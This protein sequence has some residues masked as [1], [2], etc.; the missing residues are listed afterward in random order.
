MRVLQSAVVI[1]LF[2]AG[3]V[4]AQ[5]LPPAPAGYEWARCPDIGGALLVPDGWSFR[6]VAAGD[7]LA[8]FIT[9][10]P[11]EPPASFETGL[12]FNVLWDVPGKTGLSPVEYGR[13]Y[14]DAAKS[15]EDVV[16]SWETQLGPFN[17]FGLVFKGDGEDEGFTFYHL[18]IGNDRTGTAFLVL[19]EAPTSDWEA[20]WK[21]IEPTV[22]RMLI[23]DEY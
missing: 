5:E 21:T 10:R 12:T 16:R 22:Q 23:D 7:G 14:V 8:Y 1:F 18:V 19:F 17:A 9:K 6:R 4:G 13:R 2:F 15:T 11:W 3:I 20:D